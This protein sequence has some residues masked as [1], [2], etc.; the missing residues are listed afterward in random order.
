MKYAHTNIQAFVYMVIIVSVQM[1]EYVYIAESIQ[2]NSIKF[3]VDN[4]IG[5]PVIYRTLAQKT[6][7]ITIN[8]WL[9]ACHNNIATAPTTMMATTISTSSK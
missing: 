7:W 6:R 1:N 4:S 3:Y 8:C 2:V 9:N 5:M